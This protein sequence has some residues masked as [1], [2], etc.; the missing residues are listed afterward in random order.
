MASEGSR[1]RRA[2]NVPARMAEYISDFVVEESPRFPS[3]NDL[4]HP[5]TPPLLP[6][7]PHSSSKPGPTSPSIPEE[8]V[9]FK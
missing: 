4:P 5:N 6:P 1:K 3:P 7:H 2:R 8:K 9:F